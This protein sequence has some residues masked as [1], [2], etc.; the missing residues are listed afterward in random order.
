MKKQFIIQI[1]RICISALLLVCSTIFSFGQNRKNLVDGILKNEEY[2]SHW[3]MI[4]QMRKENIGDN[5]IID[6][7]DSQVKAK[8]KQEK[9]TS[10]NR[11]GHPP[12]TQAGAPCSGLGVEA[13]WGAWTARTGTYSGGNLAWNQAVGAGIP[14]TAPRFNLTS[15]SG[16]DACTPGTNPGDPTIPVVCPGFGNASVQIGE[17]QTNGQQ[18]NCFQT[19]VFVPVPA[20]CSEELTYPLLVTAADTNFVYSYALVIQDGGHSPSDQ[21]FVSFGIYDQTG[22]AIPCGYFKYVAAAGAGPLPGFYTATCGGSTYYKPWTLVGINL[23]PYVGQTLNI[24]ITNTDCG[25]GGH[26][27]QG[28]FDFSCGTLSGSLSSGT[29]GSSANICGPIDPN[30][31]YTYLWSRNGSPYTGP[32]SATAQCIT[33]TFSTGDVFSVAVSQPSGCGFHLMFA[34]QTSSTMTVTT[35]VAPATCGATN[36]TATANVSG[37]IAGYTYAWNTIPPQYTQIATGLGP[38]TYTATVTD[39]ASCSTTQIAIIISGNSPTAAFSTSPVCIGSATQFTDNSIAIAGDPIATYSWTFGDGNTSTAQSPTN[40]YTAA[41]TYS[42]TQTITSQA[43]CTGTITQTVTLNPSPVPNF[44]STTVCFNNPTVFTNGS[45]GASQWS[46]NFGDANTS[47]QQAPSHTYGSAGTFTV[48]QVVINSFGCKDSI[49]QT[50]VVN[51]LPVASFSLTPVCFGNSTP[52]TDLSNISS[53]A[54]ST[55]SWVF[56]DPGSGPNNISNLQNPSHIFSSAGS[57]SVTL[58][59]TSHSTH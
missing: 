34:P 2:K 50:V 16:V 46:W 37:G 25:P 49:K 13:G 57:Y 56:G 15:G 1:R 45:T 8:S 23:T 59:V 51:P 38:G 18:G 36:G 5:I 9:K 54:I 58:T 28:Y 4:E 3:G 24:V 6:S 19:V 7:L 31:P 41:G 10:T 55:W 43:G 32:P 53:G 14:P 17:L 29:C 52:F 35:S 22:T 48:T 33:P 30:I 47:A 40:T 11:I 21:P 27:A 39:A 42:V 12:I 26:F 20:G 44:T